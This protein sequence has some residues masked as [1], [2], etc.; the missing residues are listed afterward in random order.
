MWIAD[1]NKPAGVWCEHA[2]PGRPGGACSIHETRYPVCRGFM[3]QWIVSPAVP[4]EL[5][6]SKS[7]VILSAVE[8]ARGD[9]LF[10]YCDPSD[11]VAWRRSPMYE[12]LKRQTR[13]PSGRP[14]AVMVCAGRHYWMLTEGAEHDLGEVSG[15][16]TFRIE[17]GPDGRPVAKLVEKRPSPPPSA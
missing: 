15:S 4:E 5:K 6:P 17:P 9:H 12:F 3:C 14:R 11:P 1:L 13:S 2:R 8:G 7:K 10:A 16:K